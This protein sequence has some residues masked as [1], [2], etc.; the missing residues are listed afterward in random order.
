MSTIQ[1][2]DLCLEAFMTV[3]ATR[4]PSGESRNGPKGSGG[5]TEPAALPERSNHASCE[6]S[7]NCA[8]VTIACSDAEKA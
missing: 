4:R 8:A 5:P 7:M 6:G 3:A 2:S 1:I